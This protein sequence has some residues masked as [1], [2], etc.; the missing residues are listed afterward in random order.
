MGEKTELILK[1]V[2]KAE[3]WGEGCDRIAALHVDATQTPR[4][5]A[6][7]TLSPALLF[8]SNQCLHTPHSKYSMDILMVSGSDSGSYIKNINKNYFIFIIIKNYTMM[9]FKI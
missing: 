4:G 2:A 1:A 7:S 6:P 8:I 9:K 3:A 5:N